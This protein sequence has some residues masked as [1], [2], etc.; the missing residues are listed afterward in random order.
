LLLP[1]IVLWLRATRPERMPWWAAFAIALA[2]GWLLVLLIAVLN[3]TPDRGAPKVFAWFFGWA[4]ALA[5]F[6]P[7]LLVY[8]SIQLVRRLYVK[9]TIQPA[10]SREPPD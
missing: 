5:W 3:E 1:V 7:C 6:L 9:R 8:G 4:F 2:L 10:R